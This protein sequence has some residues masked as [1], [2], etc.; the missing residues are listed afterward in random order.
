[1]GESAILCAE[2]P[3]FLRRMALSAQS[4]PLYMSK[5]IVCVELYPDMSR[6]EH[7]AHSTHP[8]MQG[9]RPMYTP[10]GMQGDSIMYIGEYYSSLAHPGGYYSYHSFVTLWD[11]HMGYV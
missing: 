11:T 5:S 7:S 1:M 8:G 10:K 4:Y 6:K 3:L 2:L 9:G